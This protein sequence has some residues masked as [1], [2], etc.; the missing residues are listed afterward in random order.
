MLVARNDPYTVYY[1]PGYCRLSLKRYSASVKS[2]DD[3]TIHLT[4]ASVQKKDDLYEMNKEL[5]VLTQFIFSV[6]V[7]LFI[8]LQFILCVVLY[9]KRRPTS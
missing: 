8:I 6:H 1:H 4:N 3:P 5:Q 7:L 9:L 2:L